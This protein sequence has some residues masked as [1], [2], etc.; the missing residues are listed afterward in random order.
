MKQLSLA[1][2]QAELTHDPQW[3]LVIVYRRRSWIR[4]IATRSRTGLISL[5]AHGKGLQKG[6]RSRLPQ[7]RRTG[8]AAVNNTI[9]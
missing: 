7:R 3:V 5:L 8:N 4:S 2:G 6:L 1:C 9:G